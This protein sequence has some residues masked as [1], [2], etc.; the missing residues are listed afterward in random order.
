MLGMR[1][2]S[3]FNPNIQSLVKFQDV[4]LAREDQIKLAL[5]KI[6][7][8]PF[9]HTEP[10][11]I[12]QLNIALSGTG[13]NGEEF[14]EAAITF[15]QIVMIQD[16]RAADRLLSNEAK[17]EFIEFV[18]DCII[19]YGRDMQRVN[20]RNMQGEKW[21]SF[22]DL[23]RIIENDTIKHHHNITIDRSEN[24]EIHSTPYSDWELI[25]YLLSS[26]FKS[27]A[28]DGEN[29]LTHIDV[30]SFETI[31]S[32]IYSLEKSLEEN[33]VELADEEKLL[34]ETQEVDQDNE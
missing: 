27:Y 1:G 8:E 11:I 21:W 28:M 10:E 23:D 5:K 29:R 3:E 6:T 13:D 31:R 12:R 24:V 25:E 19:D 34:E 9:T 4:F 7:S 26:V 30:N 32:Y 17:S 14:E 18:L 33:G 22:A 2:D 15:I 16:H 20:F